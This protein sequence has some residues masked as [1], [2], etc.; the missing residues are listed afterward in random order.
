MRFSDIVG[1]RALIVLLGQHALDSND[2]SIVIGSIGAAYPFESA[3]TTNIADQIQLLSNYTL[4]LSCDFM[5]DELAVLSKA[6]SQCLVRCDGSHV[7]LSICPFPSYVSDGWFIPP[8][9]TVSTATIHQGSSQDELGVLRRIDC[10]DSALCI[11]SKDLAVCNAPEKCVYFDFG[12]VVV[13]LGRK[14]QGALNG[15]LGPDEYLRKV[16]ES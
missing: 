7:A 1:N 3:V 2:E 9:E 8:Y 4:T 16:I 12:V 15:M 13:N 6:L 11:V 5:L 10:G 14:L